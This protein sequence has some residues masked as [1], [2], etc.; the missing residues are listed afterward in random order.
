MAALCQ[1]LQ[2]YE[3]RKNPSSLSSQS[4]ESVELASC[5]EL[6]AVLNQILYLL[7]LDRL[8]TEPVVSSSCFTLIC[9]LNAS[10]EGFPKQGKLFTSKSVP[11]L[12]ITSALQNVQSGK[13]NEA[14]SLHKIMHDHSC[15]G[16][17]WEVSSNSDKSRMSAQLALQVKWHKILQKEQTPWKKPKPILRKLW[18]ST[19]HLILCILYMET[20]YILTNYHIPKHSQISK[21]PL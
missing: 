5:L 16:R 10:V 3:K 4:Q 19:V 20:F 9:E 15:Q 13:V 17:S 12:L 11:D 6:Y 21:Q 14:L 8:L 7:G 1:K 2:L 18:R